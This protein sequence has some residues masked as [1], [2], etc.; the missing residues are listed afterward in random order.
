MQ[1][2]SENK[3]ILL[4]KKGQKGILHAVFGRF[5]LILLLLL[6]QV[7]LLFSIFTW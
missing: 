2:N 3:G 1:I 4:L 5:G 6:L 7:F